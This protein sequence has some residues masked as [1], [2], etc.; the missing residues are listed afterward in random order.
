MRW[1]DGSVL[2]PFGKSGFGVLANCSYCGTEATLSFLAGP[3]CSSFSAEACA[4]LQPLH[5]YWK[6]I[7]LSFPVFSPPILLSLCPWYPVLSSIFPF[8]SVFLEGLAGTILFP[9]LFYQ[10]TMGTPTLVSHG[11]MQLMSWPKEKRYSIVPSA[12]PCNLSLLIFPIYSSIFSDWRC[13]ASSKFFDTEV[14][15][16]STEELVLLCQAR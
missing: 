16:I 4:I 12:I 7:C 11:A 9:L 1:T 14:P 6:H 5:W 13:T 3:V 2:F 15:S 8:T 10:A